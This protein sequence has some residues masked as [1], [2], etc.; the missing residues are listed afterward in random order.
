MCMVIDRPR[1]RSTCSAALAQAKN[2]L[3]SAPRCC[4]FVTSRS[5]LR[6]VAVVGENDSLSFFFQAVTDRCAPAFGA[7]F[8]GSRSEEE[9]AEADGPE[10][11]PSAGRSSFFLLPWNCLQFVLKAFSFSR[12]ALLACCCNTPGIHD[13]LAGNERNRARTAVHRPPTRWSRFWF[14]ERIFSWTAHLI[15]FVLRQTTVGT[16][17]CNR[18]ILLFSKKPSKN[19]KKPSRNAFDKECNH[20]RKSV[21][22]SRSIADHSYPRGHVRYRSKAGFAPFQ[23]FVADRAYDLLALEGGRAKCENFHVVAG[24]QKLRDHAPV[25]VRA[26]PGHIHLDARHLKR[27]VLTLIADFGPLHAQR[28][29]SNYRRVHAREIARLSP[30]ARGCPTSFFGQGSTLGPCMMQLVLL[31]NGRKDERFTVEFETNMSLAVDSVRLWSGFQAR[32]AVVDGEMWLN[33]LSCCASEG[34][35]RTKFSFTYDVVQTPS[36]SMW[37]AARDRP[38]AFMYNAV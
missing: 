22:R 34:C 30:L 9:G 19:E 10:D 11:R 1:P 15:T 36:A 28:G 14:W 20:L 21:F 2:F 33:A 3:L 27:M 23:K 31:S 35:R 26:G 13:K 4:G 29:T 5:Q 16:L 18:M 7:F 12:L 24:G 25:A 38:V 6:F 32:R 17:L 37:S 8:T